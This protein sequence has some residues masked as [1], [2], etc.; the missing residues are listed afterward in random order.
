MKPGM[1]GYQC[2]IGPNTAFNPDFK[3]LRFEDFTD[4]LAGTLL[5][6]ETRRGVPWT[7]PEDLPFDMSVPLTGLGSHHGPDDSGFNALF[8]DERP[9]GLLKGSVVPK[10]VRRIG[11]NASSYG[12]SLSVKVTSAT[13]NVSSTTW[14]NHSSSVSHRSRS[15]RITRPPRRGIARSV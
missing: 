5:I 10:S 11:Y 6:G 15:S 7:K 9:S 8:A 2:V 1:T 4:G 12:T 14:S 3:P 13:P